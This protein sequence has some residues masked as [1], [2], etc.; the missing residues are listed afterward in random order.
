MKTLRKG[1]FL[2]NDGHMKITPS[3]F[4]GMDE[5]GRG[6]WAGPVVAAAV[7][8]P[9]HCRLPGL[10]DSK[11]LT[12]KKREELFDLIWAKAQVG[13]GQAS[14]E[15]VDQFGLLHATFKAYE[16]ALEAL[17]QVPDHLW[18]DGRD[19]FS[20]K[21]PH[22]SIIRGDQKVR[23]ISA[24]SVIAKVTRD[25]IMINYAQEFPDYAFEEHKGY[26]TRLHQETLQAHGA[27]RIHRISYQ[28][29]KQLQW[30]QNAFL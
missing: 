8:L 28:P 6:S 12:Q 30:V 7:I 17:P 24:A 14:H 16:R 5:A 1:R 25:R 20:F 10:T 22:T 15:E 29:L 23:A 9:N 18:I 2:C 19:K 3:I 27:S 21:V 26:G 11:L 4:A 13:V